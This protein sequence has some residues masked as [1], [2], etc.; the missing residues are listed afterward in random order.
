MKILTPLTQD[1][2]KSLKAG[3]L[4]YITG[5]IYTA[6]DAAHKKMVDMINNNQPLPIPIKDSIIYYVGP[7][8]AK[9]NEPIGSCGPTTSY[10]MDPF[11]E[12]LLKLGLRGSIGKGARSEN[13]KELLNKYNSVYFQA[14]GGTA[15][16][17]SKFVKSSKLIAFPEL[18][19]EAIR[20]LT[21]EDFP[22][23]VTYDIYGNDLI[24]D[25]IN[26]YKK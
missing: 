4:V 5:T 25:E 2:L 23:F 7:T 1:Q 22:V 12:P 18:Q 13:I 17:L 19:S 15:A 11:L 3:D 24:K 14:I 8:P 10:R 26:K 9:P 20:E 21:V 16:Y 6:R